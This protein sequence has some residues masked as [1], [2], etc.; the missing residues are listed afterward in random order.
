MMDGPAALFA[1][2]QA[3]LAQRDPAAFER[4]CCADVPPQLE[5]FERNAQWAQDQRASLVLRQARVEGEVATL[6][7]DAVAASGQV[8]PGT[9]TCTLEAGGWKIRSL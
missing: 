4:L 1:P 8:F 2:F 3:A 7:F 9:L 6:R 5:L